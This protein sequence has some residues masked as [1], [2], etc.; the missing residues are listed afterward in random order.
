[1]IRI[2]MFEFKRE[3]VHMLVGISFIMFLLFV[4]SAQFVLFGILII[5]CFVSFLSTM[6]RVPVVHDFL[7]TF[8]RECNMK[9][10][11]GKGI[12][13]FFIGSL[14]VL[15]LFS[16]NIAIA[17]ILILTFADPISHFVGANFGRTTLI[18]KK[19]YI[20]GTIVGSL[21]GFFFASFFVNPWIAFAGAFVAMFLE[22]VEIAMAEQTLDDNLLIPLVAGSVMKLLSLRLGIV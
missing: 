16:K 18:N 13:F 20:E 22:Y 9:R 21:V 4:P 7:C 11:P 2:D 17:S 12:I 10:F 5:G 6:Y 3:V 19:K 1:M 14:L 15:Q 8:E